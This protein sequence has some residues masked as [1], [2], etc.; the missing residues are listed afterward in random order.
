MDDFKKYTILVVDDEDILRKTIV[1]DFKRK[2]FQVLETDNG[3]TAL[4][5][6]KTNHVNLVVSDIRMPGGDGM[7]LLEQ[8]R[9]YDPHLPMV[10]FITGFADITEAECISKGA[11]SV[12]TKPFDRTLLMNSVLKAL[13]IA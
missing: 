13:G 11:K 5:L 1:F 7:A 2:G 9:T 4:E 3:K 12:F 10:I 8:I 6:V